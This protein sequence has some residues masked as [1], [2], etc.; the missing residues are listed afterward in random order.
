MYGST[1]LGT[2]TGNALV[3]TPIDTTNLGGRK[4]TQVEAG[5]EHSLLLADDGTVFSFG[6]NTLGVTG[7]GTTTGITTVAT[8]IVTTNLGGRRITQV[9]TGAFGSFGEVSLILSDDG[10]VFSFGDNY[11]GQLGLGTHGN[12]V[13]SVATP[14][15]TSNLDGR[16]ITQIA[17]GGQHCLLL[18]DDGT[19]F[20]FGSGGD[21]QTGL[22]N[23]GYNTV[24]TPIVTTNLMGHKIN[25][26]SAGAFNS[27]VLADDGSVFAFGS[28][29]ARQSGFPD[30][31]AR[32]VATAIDTTNLSGLAVT[33]V[34]AGFQH[35]LLIAALAGDFNH[36]GVVDAADYVVWR[37]TSGTPAGYDQWRANYGRT[38]S[39][40]SGAALP[41][42]GPLSAE[43]PE[44]A[45]IVLLT[46]T[47]ASAYFRRTKALAKVS[48]LV[49]A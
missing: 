48:K 2:T 42:A 27:L 43:V 34:S 12:T 3:A 21:G 30:T 38:L 28:S 25:Q 7:L 18:A 14:I 33:Q 5:Y 32:N 22:G 41:S 47:F 36:D 13:V 6:R 23:F 45:S 16:K 29:A 24:A 39:A 4:I 40:G 49:Q 1:G 37:N 44:P 35:S 46:L 26:I 9:A 10:T 17:T 8:P 15:D 11:Y 31:S 20:S 19:V